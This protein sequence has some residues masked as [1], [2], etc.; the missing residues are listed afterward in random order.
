M[1]NT[2]LAVVIQSRCRMRR[3]PAVVAMYTSVKEC[4]VRTPPPPPGRPT[5]A[6]GKANGAVD[7]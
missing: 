6:V 4:A 1:I 5:N 7:P 3:N 2:S